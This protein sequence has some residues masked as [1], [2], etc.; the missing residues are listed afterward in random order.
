MMPL[1]IHSFFYYVLYFAAGIVAKRNDWMTEIVNSQ[2]G[3]A[4]TLFMWGLIAFIVIATTLFMYSIS[5][6]QSPSDQAAAASSL[7]M[8]SFF[9]GFFAVIICLA[10]LQ[11]FHAYFNKG[12]KISKFFCESAYAAYILHYIFVNF[13]IYIYFH[14]I[15]HFSGLPEDMFVGWQAGQQGTTYVVL[16]FNGQTVSE[17]YNWYGMLFVCV[18]A[19]LCVWPTAFFLRKL[20]LINQVL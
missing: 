12:G 17:K 19:N 8:A 6:F 4:T 15:K 18:F 5:D 20:P 10:E 9:V 1:G 16:E 7:D 3:M 13:G 14:M 2:I 11:L